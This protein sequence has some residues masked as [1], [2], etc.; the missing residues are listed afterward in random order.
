MAA[1]GL[2]GQS[3]EGVL[4]QLRGARGAVVAEVGNSGNT[5]E[6]HVHRQLMD[7]PRA[8]TAAGLPF[9]LDDIAVSE[10]PEAPGHADPPSVPG[11]ATV[12]H[13]GVAR[14]QD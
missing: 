3:A 9:V 1:D 7:G 12:F 2:H 13:A 5:S 8:A 6:P 10:E 14:A 11:R 4:L